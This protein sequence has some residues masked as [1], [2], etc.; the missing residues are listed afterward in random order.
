MSDELKP[1]I[2]HLTLRVP[3]HDRKWSGHVCDQPAANSFC[4]MLDRI[5]EKRV[6]ELEATVAGQ[7]WAQLKPEELPPCIAENGGF[8]NASR[9]RRRF[10]H[11]Y[12][13]IA[14][15]RD[16]HGVLER[17]WVEVPE[18]TTFA[19]PFWW[20]LRKNQRSI[21]DAVPIPLAPDSVPPFESPWVFDAERQRALLKQV[22][23]QVTEASSLAIFYT[24]DGHPFGEGINRL[25]V[26]IGTVTRVSGILE[27]R[28]HARHTYPLW[29]T[30]ISHSIR[31]DGTAGFLLPY[32]EYLQAGHDGANAGDPVNEILV[33]PDS[34]HTREFSYGA[35]IAG[36]DVALATLVRCLEV[37]GQIRK[38]GIAHGPW[39]RREEWLNK[40]IAAVWKARGAY[41]GLGSALEA[42]GLR[43]GTSLYRQLVVGGTIGANDA[44]SIIDG[45]FR[46]KVAPPDPDY[47]ADLKSLRGMWIELP[48][49][50]RALRKLLSRFDLSP[51]QA[52]R[53]YDGKRRVQATL[54][55]VTDSDIIANPY[56]IAENDLGDGDEPEIS[57]GTLDRGLLPDPAIRVRHPIPEPST[58]A[59]PT[60]DRRLPAALVVVLRQMETEGDTLLSVGEASERSTRLDASTPVELPPDWLTPERESL[61]DYVELVQATLGQQQKTVFGIQLAR[62][63]R[64]EAQLRKVLL[65]RSARIQQA[66]VAERVRRSTL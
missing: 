44:W 55:T 17:T 20:M 33:V 43:L 30:L 38:H 49:E 31:P 13:N 22:F 7:G 23:D 39:E 1:A 16:S 15:V 3:W 9:W 40:Q 27:Y 26:G 46:G 6:D 35:E 60:D 59:A 66:V 51:Q 65:A 53:W 58:V 19:M 10:A 41:P 14:T 42:F 48:D 29:D 36:P 37:V 45:L 62:T 12:V 8:M 4:V 2:G 56:L 63:R 54:S 57:F 5:R 24:K 52:K 64:F 25:I 28:S 34:G 32:H 18:Y 61:K 21:D 47:A 11:P 50:R